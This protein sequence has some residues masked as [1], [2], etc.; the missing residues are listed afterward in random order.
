MKNSEHVSG[1]YFEL[2]IDK[3]KRDLSFWYRL[4]MT[5]SILIIGLWVAHGFYSLS[6]VISVLILLPTVFISFPL[7]IVTLNSFNE[8]Q[9]I[10]VNRNQVNIKKKT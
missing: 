5:P 6:P 7:I 4:V 9:E 1:N 10:T 2:K 3:E 8:K